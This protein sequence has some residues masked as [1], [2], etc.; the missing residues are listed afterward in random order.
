MNKKANKSIIMTVLGVFLII[1]SLLTNIVVFEYTYPL[2]LI[3]GFLIGYY[4]MELI[5][6]KRKSGKRNGRKRR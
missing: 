2:S 1:T 4:G 3:G 6:R 5:F